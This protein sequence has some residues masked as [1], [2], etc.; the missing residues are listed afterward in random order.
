M[1]STQ[2]NSQHYILCLLINYFNIKK[3]NTAFSFIL[4]QYWLYVIHL[5]KNVAPSVLATAM[6]FLVCYKK[7]AIWRLEMYL[8]IYAIHTPVKSPDRKL[9]AEDSIRSHESAA[10]LYQSLRGEI[11][12]SCQAFNRSSSVTRLMRWSGVEQ[13]TSRINEKKHACVSCIS[14]GVGLFEKG[15]PYQPVK[16]WKNTVTWKFQQYSEKICTINC[17]A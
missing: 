2:N 16:Q 8:A 12:F 11:G 1:T 14:S 9:M 4:N 7:W 3:V 5:L 6:K 17:P 13:I 15:Y 10:I